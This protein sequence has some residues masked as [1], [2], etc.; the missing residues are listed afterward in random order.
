[1]RRLRLA[2]VKEEPVTDDALVEEIAGAIYDVWGNERDEA[3]AVL[4]HLRER[5]CW[6]SGGRS[7]RSAVRTARSY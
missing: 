4:A 2:G 6:R 3:R 7:T 5:G 1:M